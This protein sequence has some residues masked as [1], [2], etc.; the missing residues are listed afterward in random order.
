[1]TDILNAIGY[2]AIVAVI[3]IAI[4]FLGLIILI[5]FIW[6]M[7]KIF[8]KINAD[9]AAKKQA[10]DAAAAKAAAEAAAKAAEAAP[11]P[12]EEPVMEEVT[13]DAEL[14]AVIAA[15]LAAFDNSGKALVVR[16]VRRVNAWNKSARE[17]QICRF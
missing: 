4:V 5:C 11:A 14:I 1:M 17:E 7:A 13:D 6:A 12:V 10:A 3:G 2:G 15:A 8:D 9:A 16:K